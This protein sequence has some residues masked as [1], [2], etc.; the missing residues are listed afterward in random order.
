MSRAR[1]DFEVK[2]RAIL[3]AFDVSRAP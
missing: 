2:W 1:H 3:R